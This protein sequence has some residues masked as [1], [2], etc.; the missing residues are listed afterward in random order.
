VSLREIARRAGVSHGAPLRH[1]LSLAN[2]LAHVSAEG[3][4]RLSDAM[5]AAH[6]ATAC[7]RGLGWPGRHGRTAGSG[8]PSRGC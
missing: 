6:P 2:L 7:Q 8:W 3:L 4:R 1:C 5:A